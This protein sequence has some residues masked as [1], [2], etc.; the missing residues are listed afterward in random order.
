MATTIQYALMA[1]ASYYST[2]AEESIFPVPQGWTENTEFRRNNTSSGFEAR[3]FQKDNEI[4][5]SY[6]GTDPSDLLGDMA[7]NFGLATGV[8]SAQ[9]QQAAEYYLQVR[10]A[11][12]NATI[13]FTGHSLGGGLAALMGVFFGKQALTFDQAPFANS[14]EASLILPDLATNLKTYLLGKG[15]SEGTLQG[16]TDFLAI[17]AA[18]PMG[19]IPN[20][21]LVAS[22]NV[23]GE[24]LSGAPWNIQDRIGWPSY[25]PT[26]APGVSGFDL[27]SQALLTAFLQ[28]MQTA[29]SQ[30][31]LNDVTFKLTDLMSMI[32]SRNLYRF[33][34]D[35]SNRNF[36]EWLVQN[37]TGNAMVTRFTNDLWK[38]AQDGG[39]T[40]ADDSFAAVKLVSQT[41]IAF[42][43]EKYYT[44][45]QASAGYNQELF[46][47]VTGGVRFDLADVTSDLLSTTKGY[48]LYFHNYVANSF[49][50]SDRDRIY[51][52]LRGSRDWYV[53]AGRNGMEA[54]DTQ[55]RGAF[56]LGGLGADS[57]TGG[58]GN[59][60]LVGNAGHDRLTG[61]AGTDT[62]LGGAG[63]D[64][65]DYTT[66]D[67]N[68]R[69]E[70]SDARGMIIVNGQMLVGGVK[71]AGHTDWTSPDGTIQYVMQGT[72]LVVNLN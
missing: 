44:E 11:N 16:L 68:D 62:L 64:T 30:Q 13:T 65:Y 7:A 48:G 50:P 9:L 63:F 21:S 43:M 45:T 67:G 5:I 20:S 56:M 32:F 3:V 36:L 70:D 27:H 2:R 25:I 60:L 33:D 29:P 55:N 66:G 24:F 71:K 57:L 37:E 53:Q 54:M 47:A 31:T 52:L 34:T 41:L 39:L 51:D 6:A 17:R 19:E 42:A 46:K 38:L 8:G 10:A 15:Y 1:G 12:P 22:I 61:G 35:T 69:I 40:M 58:S 14:A 23:N 18:L 26:Q 28:S 4:V 72:D 49:S 59:D